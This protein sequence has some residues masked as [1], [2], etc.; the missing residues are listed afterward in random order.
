[1]SDQLTGKPATGK[2]WKGTDAPAGQWSSRQSPPDHRKA[3]LNAG[4]VVGTIGWVYGVLGVVGGL[5]LAVQS[6][7]GGRSG[8]EY[9]YVGLGIGLMVTGFVIATFI[10]TF[11][12]IA[13]YIA[14]RDLP[15]RELA[16]KVRPDVTGAPLG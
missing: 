13:S 11:G 5:M 12:R 1:M 2:P 6:E 10:V 9:P 15:I 3:L 16:V 7:D 8:D 14:V 4:T